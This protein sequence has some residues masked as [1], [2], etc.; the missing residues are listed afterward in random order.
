MVTE[1]KHETVVT[2]PSDREILITRSFDA[3]REIVC[4]GAVV[5]SQPAVTAATRESGT[6]SRFDT[7][8]FFTDIKDSDRAD[9]E[10]MVSAALRSLRQ[11]PE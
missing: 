10:E 5:R 7:A 6:D 3:P 4:R 8:I 2:L 9:V 11:R 1:T